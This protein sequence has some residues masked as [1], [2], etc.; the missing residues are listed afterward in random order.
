MGFLEQLPDTKLLNQ[1]GEDSFEPMCIVIFGI[2]FFF[3][4]QKRVVR[5]LIWAAFFCYRH[6]VI[7]YR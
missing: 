6:L 5:V 7:G 4:A 3:A 1:T 2:G